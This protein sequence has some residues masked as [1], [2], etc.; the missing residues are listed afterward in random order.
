MAPLLGAVAGGAGNVPFLA[1]GTVLGLVELSA[2]LALGLGIAL[3]APNV[4][5]MTERQ[6]LA[7]VAVSFAFTLQQVLFG[8][9]SEFLYFRF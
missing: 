9:A 7:A 4:Y 2:L 1:G 5:E 3:F 8:R 6:R